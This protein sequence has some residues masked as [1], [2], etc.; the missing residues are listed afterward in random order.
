MTRMDCKNGL[1]VDISIPLRG[2]SKM[3][4]SSRAMKGLIVGVWALALVLVAGSQA[5]ARSGDPSDVAR[6]SKVVEGTLVLGKDDVDWSYAEPNLILEKGDLLQTNETGMAEIQ[7]DNILT[8]RIGEETR[9]AIVQMDELKVVGID[10]GRAYLRISGEL[11]RNEGF[12]LTFPSGQLSVVGS[13]LARIDVAK[14]GSA[15]LNVIR[16]EVGLATKSE[17][18]GLIPGGRS[19]S[20][21][22]LGIAIE[23]PLDVAKT[24]N[25]DAWNEQRDIALSTYRRPKQV[26]KSVVGAEDL[27]G[28]GD[29]VY[30]DIYEVEVWRPYVVKEW[31]PYYHG[32]W[33]SSRYYGWTWIPEEP[34]GYVTHHYGSWNYDSYYGWIWVPDLVW[35]AS[36]VQWV[37]YGDY[38]GWVPLGYY[39]YP[40]ITDYPYYVVDYHYGWVDTLTFSFVLYDHFYCHHG[41]HHRH[42]DHHWRHGRHRDGHHGDH[43]RDRDGRRGDHDRDRDDR[44]GDRRDRRYD[45][46]TRDYLR[47]DYTNR[48][49]V[50]RD[51]GHVARRDGNRGTDPS[52]DFSKVKY[53]N[54]R[55]AS[56]PQSLKLARSDRKGKYSREKFDYQK[57]LDFSKHPELKKRVARERGETRRVGKFRKTADFTN[58]PKR[59]AKDRARKL[60]FR[61]PQAKA[62]KDL[63]RRKDFQKRRDAK[64]DKQ[65]TRRDFNTVSPSR[66]RWDEFK[67]LRNRRQADRTKDRFTERR[68]AP[69]SREPR[70]T[71]DD[72]NRSSSWSRGNRDVSVERPESRFSR[73]TNRDPQRGTQKPQRGTREPQRGTRDVGKDLQE[74]RREVYQSRKSETFKSESPRR[75]ERDRQSFDRRPTVRTQGDPARSHRSDPVRRFQ[76]RESKPRYSP[77][78]ISRP[79]A[80]PGQA[81]RGR[82]RDAVS[83]RDPMKY[84]R[85]GY[86]G[87]DASRSFAKSYGRRG[88]RR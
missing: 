81:F 30:S 71:V 61:D 49:G 27:E 19:V 45:P 3:F 88:H 34:W 64:H 74:R 28:Y 70:K 33:Y 31:R 55:F 48:E 68:S 82:E 7:F 87:G 50:D 15:K 25:F 43:D 59:T 20:I 16:G 57:V 63:A 54:V 5:V 9:A 4:K 44:D 72:T 10:M 86:K 52:V 77:K 32:R 42:H 36:Y 1:V 6:L 53:E 22:S 65:S 83:G 73:S 78:A 67:Q 13:L 23:G 79:S 41:H 17:K 62:G 56:D 18:P 35:R 40:V 29:W 24:D 69:S 37:E 58:L 76:P 47:G 2:E 39:G 66:Q 26:A 84:A 46:H 51:G 8:L 75:V 80:D 38:V 11:S 21:D 85:G 60:D 12:M 14:D